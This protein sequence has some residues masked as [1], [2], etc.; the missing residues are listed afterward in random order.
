MI[1]LAFNCFVYHSSAC[2]VRDGELIAFA[3]EER[4]DRDK[5]T[6]AFPINAIK[7]CLEE[8][9]VT[10]N[11]VDVLGFHWKPLHKFHVRVFEVLKNLLNVRDMTGEYSGKWF[12]MLNAKRIF[13]EYFREEL[14]GR[15]KPLRFI[16]VKH[17]VTHGASAYLVSPFKD[18]AII[19]MDG[20]GEVACTTMGYGEGSKIKILQEINF[21]HSLGYIFVSLTEYL[22]FKPNS[23]EYKI[24]SLKSYGKQSRYYDIA[25]EIIKLKPN[26]KYTVDLSYFNFQKG[27]RNPWV[28]EKFIKVFGPMKPY[29]APMTETYQDIAWAFQKRLEDVAMHIATWLHR[30]TGKEYLCIA[31]GTGLNSVMNGILLQK[32][33][34]KDVFV[35]PAANDTGCCIGTA[36]YIYNTI[37]KNPRNYVFKTPYLGPGYTN[38][39]VRALLDR[40]G[41]KYDFV[42][43]EDELVARTAKSLANGEVVGWFQGRMEVGPRALGSRSILGD[44]R[45]IEMQEV[46]NVK[47]KHRESFRPFAPSV[48]EEHSQEYFDIDR[49][50]PYMTF[51]VPVRH[52]KHKVVPAITH[53]DGSARIQ[54]VNKEVSPRYWNLLSKFKALTGVPMLVNTSFNVMGEPIVCRPEEALECFLN[55]DIDHLVIENCIVSKG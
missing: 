51:V 53:V 6:G 24:M 54:T 45:D 52:D 7:Y 18:A 33:P 8:A 41:I 4:F 10:L 5:H 1:I 55:T 37:L 49:P 35:Q 42:A 9:G 29:D 23:D 16:R 21:P 32:G 2:L 34:F 36:Y 26:G 44:P 50:S 13:K 11:D 19:T 17:P 25:K 31:G 20:S 12:N 28:S 38:A 46:L 43:S 40:R 48:M 22:G 3:E 15:T 27:V 30:K 39:E 14:K 47:V